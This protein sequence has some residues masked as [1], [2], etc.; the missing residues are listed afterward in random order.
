LPVAGQALIRMQK[1]LTIWHSNIEKL[2][3]AAPNAPD[4]DVTYE[5]ARYAIKFF[6]KYSTRRPSRY[7]GNPVQAFAIDYYTALT[8]VERESLD[9][10]IRGVLAEIR[11]LPRKKA[12]DKPGGK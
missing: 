4:D 9:W 6:L 8:G 1:L 7:A 11:G 12:R 5:I 3:T 2:P 10:Q